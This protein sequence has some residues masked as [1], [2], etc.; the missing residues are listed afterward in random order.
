M[1]APSTTA[2][3]RYWEIDAL[4]GLMLVLMTVTHVPTRFTDPV[5]QPFG[6]VSAAEGFV[7]LS[8][9]VCGLV[10]GRI[11][12]A[13]GALAMRR[14]FWRRAVTLYLSQAALLLFV[15][16][17][18]T[19]LD[20]KLPQSA[21]GTLI[22]Y[23]LAHPAEAFGYALLLIYQPGFLD[24]LPMYILFMLASPWVMA[25]AQQRGWRVPL[26]LSALLW[27]AAQFGFTPW[28]Y[29]QVQQGLGVAVPWEET[30][31]FDTFAWQLLWVAGLWLG[32][33]RIAPGARPLVFP[34]ALVRAAVAIALLCL[35]WRHLGPGGQAPFGGG[36]A[37]NEPL[38]GKWQ[39]AP[40]RLLDLA[41][42]GVVCVRFGP[43]W[44]AQLPR[45]RLLETLGSASLSAFCTHLV[46]VFLVFSLWG[47]DPAGRAWWLDP[48]LLAATFAA[49]YAVAW[50]VGRAGVRPRPPPRVALP[51]PGAAPART[52][53]AAAPPKSGAADSG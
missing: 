15:F 23:Y 9:F 21:A 4:R 29:G 40:L 14:A 7:L 30:G 25:W 3:R 53:P 18:I 47:N 44:L 51:P 34:P 43:G 16:T 50:W 32:A 11:G 2:I 31:A 38:F 48:A 1:S 33:A 37:W 27:L 13:R 45:P 8:G 12:Q 49:M 41:A 10:Y 52:P 20:L 22:G 35:L 24:I 19:G 28:L 5:G 6:F 46:A 26:A 42:I 36:H 39:L 17:L